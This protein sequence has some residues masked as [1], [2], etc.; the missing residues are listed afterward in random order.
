MWRFSTRRPARHLY[1]R[2]SEYFRG[3]PDK[4]RQKYKEELHA[5]EVA[6]QPY[7]VAN[8]NIEATYQ[9][10]T[11]QFAEFEGLCLVDTLDNV[12]P[13]SIR[14]QLEMLGALS[15]TNIEREAA[16][17]VQDQRDYRQSALQREPA[18]RERQ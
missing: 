10:I 3:Q 15:D 6:I 7:Y 14:H 4:L 11:G 18:E 17:P 1:S 8:L 13:A 12:M 9:A 5:N 2:T 16:E